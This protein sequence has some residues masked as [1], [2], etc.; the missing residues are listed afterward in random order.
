MIK[1][2]PLKALPLDIILNSMGY[3]TKWE[4]HNKRNYTLTITKPVQ[5]DYINV[6]FKFVKGNNE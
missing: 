5:L 6:D 1:R 2:M 4:E 3:K